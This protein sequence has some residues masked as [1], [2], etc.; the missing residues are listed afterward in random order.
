MGNTILIVDDQT[1][2]LNLLEQ[3]LTDKN[4]RVVRAVDGHTAL[5]QLKE[6]E[7]DAVLLDYMMPAMNGLEVLRLIRDLNSQIAL[8]LLTAY[9]SPE[10]EDKAIRDG[11]Y[12]VLAKPFDPEELAHTLQSALH[13]EAA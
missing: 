5:Q 8:I 12:A 4:Y 6:V 3:E 10:L 9:Y 1:L 11:A 13:G 2:E 7:P